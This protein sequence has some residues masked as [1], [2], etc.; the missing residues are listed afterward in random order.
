MFAVFSVSHCN[1]SLSRQEGCHPLT[2][3][4]L[5]WMLCSKSDSV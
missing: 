3:I 1:F 4:L 2:D 5:I